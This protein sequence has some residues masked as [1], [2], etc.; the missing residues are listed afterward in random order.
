MSGV[1]TAGPGERLTERLR[2]RR[3]TDADRPA[4]AAMN[5]DPAVMEHL[6]EVLDQAA[7]DALLERV[8]R[9]W[10]ER[11]IG[12]WAVERRADGRLL[13]W[14][15]LNPMPPDVPA[16]GEWEVGWRLAREAWGHG[17]ATEAAREALQVARERGEARVWSMTVPANVRSVAVMRRLGLVLDRTFEHPRFP[18]GHRLRDHVLYRLDLGR[19]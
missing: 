6:P 19:P 12:L 16:A 13:G 11:G 4:F 15:G 17:Y 2:L 7:S 18:P 5:A 1:E 10:A 8:Q 9:P 14:A 3:W